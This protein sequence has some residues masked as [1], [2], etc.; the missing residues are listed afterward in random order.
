MEKDITI[1]WKWL[2]GMY[3][4]TIITAGGLGVGIILMPE[5]I[6]LMLGWPV[7]EPIAFGI[8]GAVYVAFG[9]A[10]ILG[11][12]SPLKF[13]PILLLQ[14]FYKIAWFLGVFL[15]LVLT[16]QYPSYGLPTA[17][18]FATYVIGDLIAIPFPYLFGHRY[19]L[20]EQHAQHAH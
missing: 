6:K 14:L 8:I 18:I 11:L 9:L 20:Y 1:R 16:A 10:S 13:V 19:E 3:I 7:E 5:A 15:P 17:V 12:L 4:Y 2:K